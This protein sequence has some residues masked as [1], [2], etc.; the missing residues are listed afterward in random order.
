MDIDLEMMMWKWNKSVDE[1]KQIMEQYSFISE[2]LITALG[3]EKAFEIMVF[4]DGRQIE[5]E[6]EDDEMQHPREI[7]LIDEQGKI[8]IIP[9]FELK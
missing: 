9:V 2:T 3:R 5:V 4:A 6:F 8:E 7:H 1:M